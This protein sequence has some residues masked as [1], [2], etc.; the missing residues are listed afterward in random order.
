[1]LLL[2]D[3]AMPTIRQL[4]AAMF[5]LMLPFFDAYAESRRYFDH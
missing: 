2:F 5:F 3:F 1:V 4:E